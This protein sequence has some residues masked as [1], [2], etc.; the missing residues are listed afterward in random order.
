MKADEGRTTVTFRATAK[1]SAFFSNRARKL[2]V[3]HGARRLVLR[4]SWP[5][6]MLATGDDLADRARVVLVS[7]TE[8]EDKPLKD[9]NMFRP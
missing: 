2:A 1:L 6:T 9:P 4:A 8:G 5:R 7:V 3:G